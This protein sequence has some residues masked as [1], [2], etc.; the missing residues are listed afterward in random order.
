ME[1]EEKMKEEGG[2]E[3]VG[4]C[5]GGGG[6]EHLEEPL[7]LPQAGS[8]R[9]AGTIIIPQQPGQLVQR[10]LVDTGTLG[11]WKLG[12]KTK[13]PSRHLVQRTRGTKG[14]MYKDRRSSQTLGT[15]DKRS[16]AL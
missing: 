16:I 4:D 9:H 7:R 14:R 2:G 13:G 10:H 8:V 3:G 1:E 12:T 6:E 5:G 15:T 11:T